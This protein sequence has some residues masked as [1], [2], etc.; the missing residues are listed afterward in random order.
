[1]NT[2]GKMANRRASRFQI[3]L[4]EEIALEQQVSEEDT[5][6]LESWWRYEMD[7]MDFESSPLSARDEALLWEF[8]TTLPGLTNRELLAGELN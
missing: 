5:L 6:E 1:M 7:S 4:R 2:G 3:A 8:S